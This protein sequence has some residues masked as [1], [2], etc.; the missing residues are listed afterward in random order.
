MWKRSLN[1]SDT[2]RI[3]EF[4]RVTILFI[5]IAWLSTCEKNRP[6]L[7]SLGW[8]VVSHLRCVT[9]GLPCKLSPCG[10]S[11][12]PQCQAAILSQHQS[13]CKNCQVSRDGKS[14]VQSCYW[15]FPPCEL[16]TWVLPIGISVAIDNA[17]WVRCLLEHMREVRRGNWS[18]SKK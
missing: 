15:G 1:R 18:W 5:F 7:G 3:S 16:T 2:I 6:R 9:A 12:V 10:Q 17:C 13:P 8:P 4:R 11:S 14:A